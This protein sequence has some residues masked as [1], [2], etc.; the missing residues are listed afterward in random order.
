MPLG[1]LLRKIVLLACGMSAGRRR[2]QK[3]YN[4]ARIRIAQCGARPFIQDVGPA[5]VQA[6]MREV[7][8]TGFVDKRLNSSDTVEGTHLDRRE[9]SRAG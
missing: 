6:R 2:V 9:A 1:R 3:N 8:G 5:Y 7:G 4:L